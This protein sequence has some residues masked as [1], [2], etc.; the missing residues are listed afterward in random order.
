MD[1]SLI[2]PIQHPTGRWIEK[3]NNKAMQARKEENRTALSDV[4]ILLIGSQSLQLEEI[5]K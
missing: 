4:M 1:I 3:E 2:I 5:S